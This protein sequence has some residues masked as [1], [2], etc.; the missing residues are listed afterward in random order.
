MQSL[1]SIEEMSKVG[2]ASWRHRVLTLE[3]VIAELLVKN[4][5]MRFNLQAI[6][7]QGSRAEDYDINLCEH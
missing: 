3:I 6:E 7:Q 4:Q 5:D 2:D 1:S